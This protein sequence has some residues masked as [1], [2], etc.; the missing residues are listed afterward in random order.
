MTSELARFQRRCFNMDLET[1]TLDSLKVSIICMSWTV[2]LFFVGL[3]SFNPID[4]GV[5]E[6][7][8]GASKNVFN[9]CFSRSKVDY[10]RP[11]RCHTRWAKKVTVC[12]CRP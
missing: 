1:G 4:A 9:P 5:R 12:V 10:A 8:V 2:S 11:R 6:P 3:D 7:L